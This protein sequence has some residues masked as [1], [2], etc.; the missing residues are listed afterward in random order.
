MFT[1]ITGASV[2][3]QS[4]NNDQGH[5]HCIKHPPPQYSSSFSSGRKKSYLHIFPESE[6]SLPPPEPNPESL[7]PGRCRSLRTE[8]EREEKVRSSVKLV[9]HRTHGCS[10]YLYS[11]QINVDMFPFFT[12]SA[13]FT[14]QMKAVLSS[15]HRHCPVTLAAEPDW[16]W[17][18]V[19]YQPLLMLIILMT[20]P[21]HPENN[22]AQSSA[23]CRSH[24][25]SLWTPQKYIKY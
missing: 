1:V 8:R 20:A 22:R 13:L 4:C 12:F 7:S 11:L 5:H 14:N 10:T 16:T 18:V 25:K 24:C 17:T 2:M 21:L 3:L 6:P 23:R 19:L 15:R 9:E